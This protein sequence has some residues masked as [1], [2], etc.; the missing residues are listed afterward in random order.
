MVAPNPLCADPAHVCMLLMGY[1]GDVCGFTCRLLHP[2]CW[3]GCWAEQLRAK[4]SLTFSQQRCC[5]LLCH[6]SLHKCD[7]YAVKMARGIR[8][9]QVMD[10]PIPYSTGGGWLMVRSQVEREPLLLKYFKFKVGPAVMMGLMGLGFAVGFD[11]FCQM[12]ESMS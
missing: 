11:I 12:N 6:R 2:G 9:G 5:L 10:K 7:G 1:L 8:S 4:L 3:R